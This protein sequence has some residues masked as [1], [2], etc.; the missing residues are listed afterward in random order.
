MKYHQLSLLTAVLSSLVA[1]SITTAQAEVITGFGSSNLS[2]TAQYLNPGYTVSNDLWTLNDGGCCSTGMVD[3][4]GNGSTLEL[5]HGGYDLGTAFIS[6]QLNISAGFTVSFSFTASGTSAGGFSFIVQNDPR[7]ANAVGNNNAALGYGSNGDASRGTSKI[8]NSFAIGFWTGS[9]GHWNGGANEY[10]T[11]GFATNGNNIP[12]TVGYGGGGLASGVD[13]QSGT[14]TAVIVY[15]AVE[16]TLK[17]TL[18]GGSPITLATGFNA[19]TYTGNNAYI[20]F[21]TAAFGAANPVVMTNFALTISSDLATPSWSAAPVIGPAT[22]GSPVTVT[23][24]ASGNP[25]PTYTY[26]WLRDGMPIDGA[27]SSTYTPVAGDATHSL[28]CEV[29]ATNTQGAASA[30]SNAQT[31]TAANGGITTGFAT[32]SGTGASQW[33]VNAPTCCTSTPPAITTGTLH[34]QHTGSYGGGSVFYNTPQSLGVGSSGFTA[35]FDLQLKAGTDLVSQGGMTF[36]LQNDPRGRT[37][38]GSANQGFSY[39]SNGYPN[40]GTAIVASVAFY[41]DF[42]TARFGFLENP[43]LSSA[44]FHN[45]PS[46]SVTNGW[47]FPDINLD[48]T[49]TQNADTIHVTINYDGVKTLVATLSDSTHPNLTSGTYILNSADLGV[50]T[51]SSDGTAYVGFTG[52][53]NGAGYVNDITNVIVTP[54]YTAPPDITPDG[55]TPFAP[56]CP[57][58]SGPNKVWRIHTIGDSITNGSTTDPYNGGYRKVLN[59]LLDNSAAPHQMVGTKNSGDSA[60]IAAGQA[61]NDG[62]DGTGTQYVLDHVALTG[63]GWMETVHPDITLLMIGIN[64]DLGGGIAATEA[65]LDQ[66]VGTIFTWAQTNNPEFQL[67]IARISPYSF[68]ST[69]VMNYGNYIVDTLVPKYQALGKSITVVDQYSQFERVDRSGNPKD[70]QWIDP[71]LFGGSPHPNQAGFNRMGVAWYDAVMDA[72]TSPQAWL[73]AWRAAND[74]PVDGSGN[75]ALLASPAGDGIANLSKFALGINANTPG[76]QGRLSTGTMAVTGSHYLM[77]TYTRPEPAPAGVT[78]IPETSPDLSGSSWSNTNVVEVSSTVSESGTL[79]TITVRD[80]TSIGTASQRFLR[81]RFT[82]P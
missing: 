50:A 47:Y 60:L 9:G 61:W 15:D 58:Y 31:V 51:S 36:I 41:I 81:L 74:L 23:G 75:G 29:T 53:D 65:R 17:L 56:Y 49:R 79:R 66:I 42:Y 2:P 28:V 14:I 44:N 78:Y 21:G 76:Y 19:T 40:N 16:G 71:Y 52:G 32:G 80:N 3:I 8:V 1:C 69:G 67:L 45:I 43:G 48:L 33:S 70:S 7:G 77:L 38:I 35:S 39:G 20:G 63:S 25:P 10:Y 46:G 4:I 26:R 6:D 59:T 22:V 68:Y 13:F 82:S 18:N 11:L 5:G 54:G 12:S 27:V 57:P 37:A 24:T 64:D 62:W 72:T 30:N 34:L 73:Q 55:G